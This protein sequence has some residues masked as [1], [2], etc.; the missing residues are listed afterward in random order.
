MV[1]EGPENRNFIAQGPAATLVRRSI[2]KCPASVPL[3]AL[4]TRLGV[5]RI[6]PLDI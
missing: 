4:I 5:S 6:R 1:A 3:V 2:T